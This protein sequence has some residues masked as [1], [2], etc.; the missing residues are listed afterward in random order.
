MSD[1][2]SKVLPDG[3][4]LVSP[5]RRYKILSVIGR[6][7]FGITYK[8]LVVDKDG[9]QV[10][11]A[12]AYFAIKELFIAEYSD[13]CEDNTVKFSTKAQKTIE[14][15]ETDFVR[16]AT[17]LNRLG[18]HHPNIVF[19][20]EVFQAN[21]TSYYAMDFLEGETLQD[22]IKRC[23]PQ[24]I[25]WA[26]K[27]VAPLFDALECM[28]A[29]RMTHLD[30]KPANIIMVERDGKTEPVLIDFGLSKHYDEAGNSTSLVHNIACSKG[31]A[32]LEQYA[33]LQTFTPQAD[34]YALAA[35]L[36]FCLTGAAPE[37]ASEISPKV[38]GSSLPAQLPEA[39]RS[40]ILRAM[41]KN[42]DHRTPSVEAL[43]VDLQKYMPADMPVRKP[44]VL[45]EPVVESADVK[46]KS[47]AHEHAQNNIVEHVPVSRKKSRLPLWGTLA[48]VVVAGVAAAFFLF[49]ENRDSRRISDAIRDDDVQVLTEYVALD[50]VRAVVALA[51]LQLKNGEFLESARLINKLDKMGYTSDRVDAIRRQVS[52]RAYENFHDYMHENIPSANMEVNEATVEF[53]VDMRNEGDSTRLL[54]GIDPDEPDA[55]LKRHADRMYNRYMSKAYYM[56]YGSTDQLE[57]YRHAL[58]FR[59]DERVRSF[60]KRWE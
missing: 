20:H 50:S 9:C 40:A 37:I 56:D 1:T 16:E 17:M 49:G 57:A 53:A 34:V 22:Y 55:V 59:D 18:T 52:N 25:K 30:I 60:I 35:T 44:I 58:K 32:P 7:G 45:V 2:E 41:L 38:I 8:A 13:R 15:A 27:L 21:N 36:Y 33:G 14:N 29:N 51:K 11:D 48:A 3:F 46:R 43:R 31:Y 4:I 47:A 24:P 42:K 23:G 26:L 10:G 6:G 39:A 5:T 12:P 19:I 28:H 54:L